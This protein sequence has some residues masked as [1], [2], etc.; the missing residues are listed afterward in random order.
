VDLVKKVGTIFFKLDK[1]NYL[2]LLAK[3]NSR[4]TGAIDWR[5]RF[6]KINLNSTSSTLF[7]IGPADSVPCTIPLVPYF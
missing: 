6:N 7:S 5:K 1:F 3:T 2:T 4:G